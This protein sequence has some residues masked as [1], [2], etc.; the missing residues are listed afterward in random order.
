MNVVVLNIMKFSCFLPLIIGLVTFNKIDRKYYP[1]VYMML[2]DATIEIIVYICNMPSFSK[3]Y[4]NFCFNIYLPTFFFLSL[5][6]VYLN[7]FISKKTVIISFIASLPF[8]VFNLWYNKGEF[9]FPFYYLSF[10]SPVM[11]F[12]FINILSK[13]VVEINIKLVNNFWF[14][15]ASFS[16]LYHAFTLLIFSLYFF[17]LFNTPNGRSIL[18]IH[19]YVNGLS[20]VAFAFAILLIPS[21]NK[22]FI[23]L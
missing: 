18:N 4:S 22:N 13:Q 17:S 1:F 20:Y 6:F 3:K 9:L 14:W 11:L 10:I 12:I 15:I 7:K 23:T 5:R 2:A 8:L 19:H 16:I 21:K